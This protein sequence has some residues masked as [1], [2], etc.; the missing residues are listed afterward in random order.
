MSERWDQLPRETS[1]SQVTIKEGPKKWWRKGREV[2]K[3]SNLGRRPKVQC[4]IN[5]LSR[6][7]LVTVSELSRDP[8]FETW[9]WTLIIIKSQTGNFQTMSCWLRWRQRPGDGRRAWTRE[10]NIPMPPQTN[11][12]HD[13]PI[14]HFSEH[15]PNISQ[16]LFD[17]YESTPS[18]CS[19]PRPTQ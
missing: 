1:T 14:I 4:A 3:E 9:L 17:R 2:Q 15:P 12:N 10:I 6:L 11:K 5:S 18:P 13:K 7:L 16:E 8:K 19:W